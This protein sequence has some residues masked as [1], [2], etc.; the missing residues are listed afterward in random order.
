MA[1]LSEAIDEL[2]WNVQRLGGSVSVPSNTP[3]ASGTL[4]DYAEGDDIV[5]G[6]AKAT[7]T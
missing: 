2:R 7:Q 3:L 6:V 1:I 4:T 5:R